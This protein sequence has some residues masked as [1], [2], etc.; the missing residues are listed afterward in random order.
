MNYDETYTLLVWEEVP[1]KSFMFL[2]P[3]SVMITQ[4]RVA[5]K[6]AQSKYVNQDDTNDGLM[7]VMESVCGDVK[8][9]FKQYS[10]D[11]KVPITGKTITEV[12]HCGFIL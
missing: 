2:I 12:Y 8:G 7:F 3:N 6:E 4:Y 11:M 5:L 9:I 1:E 10:V